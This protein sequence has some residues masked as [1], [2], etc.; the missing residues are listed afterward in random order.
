MTYR[1]RMLLFGSGALVL[2]IF[3]AMSVHAVP[4]FGG[5]RHLYRDLAVR[6]ALSH[7]TANVVSSVNFD[8]RAIDTLGEETI[9]LASVLGVMALLRPAIEERELT[10]RPGGYALDSTRLMGYLMMPLTFIVGLTLVAHGHVSPG[11]GFQG[12]AI[13]TTALHLLYVTGSFRA[14]DRLR[15]VSVLDVAEIAGATAF[16]VL[17]L[18]GLVFVGAFLANFLPKG[19]LTQ[20]FSSGTVPLFN[21][22]VGVE[23]ACGMT[24]VLAQFLAQ[25]I[26][27]VKGGSER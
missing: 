23:V 4:A 8:L 24:V 26:T 18:C 20:L 3:F 10:P 5:S 15:R 14:L 19:Q 17:G 22:A 1:V 21:V 25:E 12:G 2:A 13:I 9:L 11:G 16:A 7:A 27:I 6:A